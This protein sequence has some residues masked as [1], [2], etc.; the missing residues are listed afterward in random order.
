MTR[1][2]THQLCI[3]VVF[4]TEHIIITGAPAALCSWTMSPAGLCRRLNI[5]QHTAKTPALLQSSVLFLV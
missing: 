3:S 4:A 5:Y 2:I 1:L